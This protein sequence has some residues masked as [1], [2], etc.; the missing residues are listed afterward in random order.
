MS[1]SNDDFTVVSGLAAGIDRAAHE[2]AIERNGRTIAVIGTPLS[3]VYPKEHTTLQRRI[4]QQFLLVSPV[5]V[6]RYESQTSPFKVHVT[7]TSEAPPQT[8]KHVG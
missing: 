6:K 5:P 8:N 4:A 2:T 7:R 3:Q 1:S